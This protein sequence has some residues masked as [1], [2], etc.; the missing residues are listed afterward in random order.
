MKKIILG[1]LVI[2]STTTL[3]GCTT[4][5]TQTTASS[6][7]ETTAISSSQ[8]KQVTVNV[9]LTVA[10][11]E[12]KSETLTANEGANLLDTLK[13]NFTIEETDGFITSIDGDA[14]DEAAGKYWLF[15]INDEMSQVGAAEVI[16]KEGDTIHFTLDKI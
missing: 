16:L 11:E 13:S 6:T 10:G 2:F 7:K 14:Q 9:I 8:E 1:L 12:K 15:T 5:S 3:A 4:N